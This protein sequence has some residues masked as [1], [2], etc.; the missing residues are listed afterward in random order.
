MKMLEKS[1]FGQILTLTS[2][3]HPLIS[4]LI[5]SI[6]PMRF[7]EIYRNS[8]MAKMGLPTQFDWEDN[9]EQQLFNRLVHLQ[10]VSEASV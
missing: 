2:V 6:S 7:E 1:N 4:R 3:D 10:L 5:H 8:V 9:D